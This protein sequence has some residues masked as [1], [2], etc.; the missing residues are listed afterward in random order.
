MYG[1]IPVKENIEF[2][3][4]R[5]NSGNNIKTEILQFITQK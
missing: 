4:I 1:T 2:L 5:D 3:F